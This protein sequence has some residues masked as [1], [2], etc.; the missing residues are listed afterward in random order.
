MNFRLMSLACCMLLASCSGWETKKITTEE[1]LHQEWNTIDIKEVDTYP[2]FD[3]CDSL[4]EKIA[5]KRCFED[6]VTSTLYTELS[7]LTIIV[8]ESVLDT[9]WVDFVVNETGN[10]CLDSIHLTPTVRKE[11][12]ELSL[13]IHDATQALP[14]SHP[15]IKRD[16]PVKTRFKVPVILKVN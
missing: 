13:W 4:S 3:H 2:S 6:F 11:I 14:K 16:I 5:L 10:F 12:P 15:A 9:V 1:I 7:N 8:Q